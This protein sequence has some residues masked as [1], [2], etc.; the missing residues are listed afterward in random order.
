MN[1]LISRLLYVLPLFLSAVPA[2]VW[3]AQPAQHDLVRVFLD[4]NHCDESYLKKEVTFIDYVRNRED[5]DV[6]LL[7]T[8]QETG[9]GGAQWTLKFIGL[10]R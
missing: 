3:Q 6:H 1:W 9:S 7:V 8:I 2:A 5:A 10:G 4:C